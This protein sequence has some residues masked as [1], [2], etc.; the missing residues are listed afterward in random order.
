MSVAYL[1]IGSNLG[2][3]Q[4]NIK[5]A[6]EKLEARKG[7]QVNESSPVI[8]TEPE[9]NVDQPKFLNACCKLETTLYPDELLSVLQSI[10]REM[11]R[12]RSSEPKR[13]SNE[14]KL[15]MLQEGNLDLNE[16]SQQSCDDKKDE[17]QVNE[18]RWGPRTIDLDILFYDDIIMKGNN[19]IIPHPLLDKRSFVLK[20]LAQ[21]AGDFMH[22]V[23]KK[24]ITDL[25]QDLGRVCE[26]S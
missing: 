12:D 25:Y 7:I 16:R 24:T 17:Q 21:I 1:G 23:L 4:E 20:P 2:D 19:L 18:K 15:R 26:G 5:Q 10:E 9:G 6:I 8:E 14:D 3:R 22:P 11:G 13:I